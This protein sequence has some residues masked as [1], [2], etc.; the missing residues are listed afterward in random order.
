MTMQKSKELSRNYVECLKLIQELIKLVYQ[1]QM[2][3]SE[4]QRSVI[5]AT[6]KMCVDKSQKDLSSETHNE[7]MYGILKQRSIDKMEENK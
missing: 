7:I 6:I 4:K 2:Q 1:A 5:G 3:A